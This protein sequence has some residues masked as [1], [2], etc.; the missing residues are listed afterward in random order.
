MEKSSNYTELSFDNYTRN[1]EKLKHVQTRDGNLIRIEKPTTVI[2]P[3]QRC[4]FLI[5]ID[6]I[7]QET[8]EEYFEIMVKDGDSS[9]FF[10][11]IGEI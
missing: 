4:E 1:L 8:V 11:V 5:S 9:L 7:R 2:Q 10:Q 3:F 6:C